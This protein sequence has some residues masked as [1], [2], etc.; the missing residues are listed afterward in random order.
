MCFKIQL[1][2]IIYQQ[3]TAIS[4]QQQKSVQQRFVSIQTFFKRLTHPWI[5]SFPHTT[6][7]SETIFNLFVYLKI[8]SSSEERIEGAGGRKRGDYFCEG[9]ISIFFSSEEKHICEPF[10]VASF[11]L[12][13]PEP[14]L[15]C[16]V[17]WLT[18]VVLMRLP[19]DCT[20]W[21]DASGLPG[22]FNIPE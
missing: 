7:P 9:V 10:C 13:T 12:W 21:L 11:L 22:D 16:Q 8:V 15:S 5:V 2:C 20:S 6:S 14:P 18:C 19:V 3:W 4:H 17:I 1:K